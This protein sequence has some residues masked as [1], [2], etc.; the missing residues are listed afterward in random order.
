M[1]QTAVEDSSGPILIRPDPTTREDAIANL[2]AFS[3]EGRRGPRLGPPAAVPYNPPSL[4]GCFG[5]TTICGRKLCS[6]EPELRPPRVTLG[7]A[8]R[9]IVPSE[10]YPAMVLEYI[11]EPR[12]PVCS[13]EAKQLRPYWEAGFCFVSIRPE[14]WKGEVLID[15]SDIVCPW[16]A[17]WNQ[18]LYTL[19]CGEPTVC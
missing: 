7:R 17:G 19:W 13:I 2:Y 6:L 15:M 3:D 11:P 14:N 10:C 4:R 5:W 9:Q 1:I 8:R 16:H 18:G 12:D